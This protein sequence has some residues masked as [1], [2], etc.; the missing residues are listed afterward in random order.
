MKLGGGG[1][2]QAL[3][4]KVA[5]SY[6]KKGV[7]TKKAEQIGAAI[8][9]KVGVKKYGK[10]KMTKMAVAGKKRASRGKK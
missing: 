5:S 2:F 1:K 6:K 3:K 4:K 9:A 8:A 10:A 7:S